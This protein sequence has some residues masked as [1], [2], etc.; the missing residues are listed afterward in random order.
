MALP[1]LFTQ[2]GKKT[3]VDIKVQ[4]DEW[5]GTRIGERVLAQEKILLDQ[6]LPS[7]F[8]YH[9][10]QAGV[11][12]PD[13]WLDSSKVSHKFRVSPYDHENAKISQVKANLSALPIETDSIDVAVLHHS[14]DF[15]ADVHQVLRET[16]RAVMPGGTMVVIGFN[17]WSLWGIWR[18]LTFRF[19]RSPWTSRFVSPFRLSDWLN[20]LDFEVE[21][22]ESTLYLPP[23]V[24]E[25]FLERFSG[26]EKFSNVWLRHFGAVYILVAKKRVSCVTPIRPKWRPR[27]RPF[28][29]VPVAQAS[30]RRNGP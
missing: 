30:H 9:M 6:V 3:S 27:R 4:L 7:L 23:V 8:G 10:L 25:T 22:S 11:A 1:R 20:L 16:A 18:Y 13:H 29:T 26:V 17:P 12:I 24:N 14:L 2:Q 21:G 19:R 28:V 15:E 5:F